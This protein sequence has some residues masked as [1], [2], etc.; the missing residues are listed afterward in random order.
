MKRITIDIAM[1]RNGTDAHLLARPDNATGNLAAVS[2]QD[3][4]KLSD[5][6]FHLLQNQTSNV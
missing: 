4:L 3:L 2:D 6:R 1:D 5:F